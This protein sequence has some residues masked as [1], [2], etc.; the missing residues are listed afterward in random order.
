MNKNDIAAALA[1]GITPRRTLTKVKLFSVNWK[2][3]LEEAIN[4]WLGAQPADFRLR[5]IK[6]TCESSPSGTRHNALI[7]YTV[8]EPIEEDEETQNND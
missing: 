2:Q 6:Y 7:I 8:L 1:L 4:D 5:D 3:G